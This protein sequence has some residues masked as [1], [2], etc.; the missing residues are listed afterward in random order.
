MRTY[1]QALAY[2]N[3]FVNYE[4]QRTAPYSAETLNLDRM[5]ALLERLGNPQHAYPTIHIAGTK[6]KG[7]TAAMI[8]SILHA[9]G[10]R[11]GL[12]TSPHLHTFRERMRVSGEPISRESL[13]AL[14]D[15]V[16]PHVASVEGITWFEIVTALGFLHFARSAIDAGVIEVGLG[17]RFDATNV[18]TPLVAVIT[19]LSLDHTAWLGNTLE[20]IAFEKAGIIKPGVPVVSAPQEP[21]A[22]AVLERIAAE[23]RAPLIV[24]GRDVRVERGAWGLDSQEFTV[25]ASS[26]LMRGLSGP[27]FL[28]KTTFHI[29]LPGAHQVVNAAVAVT[30]LAVVSLNRSRLLPPAARDYPAAK[31]GG[32]SSAASRKSDLLSLDTLSIDTAAVQTGLRNTHWPGRFEIARRE[33]PLIFDGAHN[34]DSAQKLASALEE[35]FPGQ[36]WMLIFGSS[37]DKDIAGMLDALLPLAARAIVTRAR[38]SRA[39][40]VESI[41]QRVADRRRPVEIASSVHDAVQR[42]IALGEPTV[43]TGS[44]Y[45]VAEARE[46]WL[47]HTRLP[48]PDRDAG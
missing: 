43:V 4:R 36:R 38:T 11:T 26:D 42:A 37:S 1:E 40:D 12:Y 5:R 15:E 17:G 33:P 2:L 14:V 48:M 8:E 46:A 23:R 13:A 22:L 19:S 32:L 24:V 10:R 7:S 20:Q 47:A 30:A 41:A 3:S 6:G 28:A 44:L 39:A 21:E 31:C 9:V 29:P 34:A 27:P 45:I 18:I 16:E 25:E 35:C